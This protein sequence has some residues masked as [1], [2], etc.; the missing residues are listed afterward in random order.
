MGVSQRIR[1][2]VGINKTINVQLEQDFSH[3]E[4]LSLKIQQEDVYTKSC[5][6]YGVVI[7]R[8]TANNGFGI[9]NARV[10]I[11]VP[12]LP[13]DR[14]RP[15]I[16]SIYPY[17]TPD[18]K[19]ED[20]YRYN[21]LPYEK[22]HTNHVPTGTFPS[23][24]DSLT[25]ELAIEIYDKYYKYT[26]KTNESG[27][28]MIMGVPL[29]NQIVFMD[30]DLSDMGEFSLTPQDLI[31]MGRATEA[32]VSGPIFKSSNNL[33]SLPQIVSLRKAIDVSPLWGD[34]EIC[35]I[36][37]NRVDFDLRDDANIDIQPTSVFMGSMFSS[38]DNKTVKTK[39]KP[40]TE[41][42]NNC[43]LVAG[44]GQILCIRQTIQQDAYGLP[45]LEQ[46]RFDGGDDVIESDGAW[47]VDL[48][49]NLDYV[50]IN[51][52]GERVIS[53]DP[54]V[55]IPT[56]G[57]YRFK[58]K[59]KQSEDLGRPVVRGNY[60][61]PNIRE[62]GWTSSANDPRFSPGSQQYDEFMK[63][64]A[65]SLNWSDYV[66]QT[67]T[68]AGRKVL[69]SFVDCEDRF[70]PFEYNK[71]YTVSNFIDQYHK[72]TNRGRFI[73]IKQITDTGC[74]SN[75]YKFP[76]NDGV[77]NT[78]ILFS[79][80]NFML[81]LITLIMIPL[82][83][84]IHV[85][86]FIWPVLK[87]LF[88]F[89]YT[90]IA[91]IV[92]IICRVLDAVPFVSISCQRP[93]NPRDFFNQIG[94][95][96]K[97][98]KIP[99]ITFPECEICTC[100]SED[101]STT[102][103]A[104]ASFQQIAQQNASLSCL[105]DTTNPVGFGNVADEQ[106]CIDDIMLSPVSGSSC[107]W[108][109]NEEENC[110]ESFNGGV[111]KV[112]MAGNGTKGYWKRTPASILG[113][114]GAE[115]Y[116]AHSEDL[117]LGERINLFN[118]KAK[119]FNNLQ[120]LGNGTFNPYG[121]WNQIKVTVR[122][123]L[124]ANA[125]KYHFDNVLALLVDEGCGENFKTGQ[126][127]CFNDTS[128][129]KDVNRLSGNTITYLNQD[130][131]EVRL[132]SVTGNPKNLSSVTYT[133]ADPNHSAGTRSLQTVY[134]VDQSSGTTQIP[135]AKSNGKIITFTPRN[136][137][138]TSLIN[139]TYTNLRGD[140]SSLG[141]DATFDVVVSNGSVVSTTIV[142]S[143]YDYERGEE[144]TI[145]GGLIGGVTGGDDLILIVDSVSSQQFDTVIVQKFP[146]DV[147]Y[148]Q[149]ITATTYGNFINNN[150]PLQYGTYNDYTRLNFNSFNY[151]YLANFQALIA[152]IYNPN[153]F[154][155]VGGLT[156]N[157]DDLVRPIF[158]M[159]EQRQFYVIFLMKGVDPNSC[160]Q[161]TSVDVSK[162][163]GYNYGRHIITG[164]Y[165]LNIPI[166]PGL[167]LP[168][169][170]EIKFTTS[171]SKGSNIFFDSYL[172]EPTNAFSGFNT[173]FVA[174]Y[175][176]LDVSTMTSGLTVGSNGFQVDDTVTYS[177]LTTDKVNVVD[178]YLCAGNETAGTFLY[179]HNTN[180][181]VFGKKCYTSSLT[182]QWVWNSGPYV[183]Q[184]SQLGFQITTGPY[185]FHIEYCDG[186]APYDPQGKRHRG[187]YEKEYIEGG[188]YFYGE[189]RPDYLGCRNYYNFNQYT[190]QWEIVTTCYQGVNIDREY[191]IY[192]SPV[193]PSGTTTTFQPATQKVV[194]RTDRLPTSSYR[195]DT[196]GNNTFVLQQNRGFAF[197]LLEDDGTVG[198]SYANQSA[199]YSS[200][201]FQDDA[202][203]QFE[204]K[205][206]SS[207]T[208]AGMVPLKCYQG[209]GENFMV[210]TPP[211]GCYDNPSII[212]EGCYV[213][214][215]KAITRIAKDFKAIAEW[216]TR[217]KV[218]MAACRG[219][220][221]HAFYNNW[222]NGSLFMPPLKNNRFFTRPS[223]TPSGNQ[224]FNKF[225]KDIAVLQDGTNSFFYRSSPFNGTKFVGKTSPN[226]GRNTLQLLYP[227]TIMDL[228]PRDQ[229]SYE[230]TLSED[231]Y[232]YNMNKLKQTT[233]Q[234]I[235][236]ILNLFMISRQ[237]S[238][239]F[240]QKLFSAG[241]ASVATFFS[242]NKR[243]FDGDYS[244]AIS[245]N[246]E[247]GVDEF[248]FE[249]YDYSTGSTAGGNSFFVGNRLIGIFYSSDTQTRDF[250]SPR[251]IIRNDAIQPGIY[252]KLDIFSQK[253]PMYKW[254]IN[255]TNDSNSLF[256]NEFNEWRTAG[257]DIQTFGYQDMDR[258]KILY[259]YFMG[260]TNLPTFQNGYIFNVVNVGT[261]SYG[262]EG[263]FV[264]GQSLV[265][266]G[267]RFTVGAPYFFYFGVTRGS[268]ALDKF[269]VK[270]LGFEV[271]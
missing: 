119:Y 137:Q 227:T 150:P 154:P 207:F 126:I 2:E 12:L 209:Y 233:Y 265:N 247:H 11:F 253:V 97:R 89:V 192:F 261:N 37:I 170:N 264:P 45:I 162:L 175:S 235:S 201:D 7:G 184:Q 193:Y 266:P 262:Y 218:N 174:N 246:S 117:T 249:T 30:L 254:G 223:G 155:N 25:N 169:H 49:M 189:A 135:I 180:G 142:N 5:A 91:W 176:A 153:F 203:S 109:I 23:R 259:N 78:D 123:D 21:L 251:R 229:F 134:A 122:P 64:Y 239:S 128:Q 19:N 164:Q 103:N 271:V 237:I 56:K 35:Q 31:R 197:F 1:T 54:K 234:D 17:N 14:S 50:V 230:L 172:Y 3:L 258:T 90:I 106:R 219:V 195:V 114:C 217:F 84:L 32:Q 6:D 152:E 38:V 83:P 190:S 165:K 213:L 269:N 156:Y 241:D 18:D 257:S 260:Y 168:R 270:Y 52:F 22:S 166:Q 63:S 10:S 71:V 66:Y 124:P 44:P 148:Y 143:G 108:A 112:L 73:G 33:N 243:R 41:L 79:F 93:I 72:G 100:E 171:T 125:G 46:Y 222:I 120:G 179:G 181:N 186:G 65:F 267:P 59:W 115:R 139:G 98:I 55:G 40:A 53:N 99:A 42:G 248:D 43:N 173:N 67:G 210:A 132:I 131:D 4:I 161:T 214:V 8:I 211:N 28:Y 101:I 95:P 75:I 220:F 244:Q 225:C 60:L 204:E 199:G 200:G 48:P 145:L 29:G 187:Y 140:T 212:R 191:F 206:Q 96:F 130:G 113:N 16:T 133:F 77:R 15:E 36:A 27:D 20:G 238:S 69:Q 242:R 188:S 163:F 9:P 263:N 147:E 80:I 58:I 26:V 141:K 205:I 194:M 224:P 118:L 70:Y 183:T 177:K 107:Q 136:P 39:C 208:C 240:W 232:G 221:G 57:K 116:W 151:R 215:D 129:T 178:G 76:T 236:S 256:G 24:Y 121:G 51:E 68:T 231:Y 82:L 196:Q 250:I 228:G 61:V 158:T 202:E 105:I 216:K 146:T 104:A 255:F 88:T 138:T 149:V 245:V 110:A 198:A 226:N 13:Q 81:V 47:L 62:Y 94:D 268:N 159:P 87:L 127:I 167:V 34:Q 102:D 182:H 85:L 157:T 160:R 92:Y 86:A 252:D 111:G 144:I 74:D 185:N